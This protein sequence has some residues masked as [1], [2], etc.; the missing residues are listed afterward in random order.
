M[1][2]ENNNFHKVVDVDKLVKDSKSKIARYFP[3]FIISWIKKTLCQDELNI[4]H[5]KYLDKFGMDYVN[6]L[7]EELDLKITMHNEDTL[8]KAD[9]CIFVANHPL[10]AIDALSFLHCIHKL[11]GKVISPSNE[12][13][14][15]IPNLR[16]LIV[17]VN[18]FKRND[19]EHIDKINEVFLSDAQIMIFPAGL[20]SRKK[21]GQIKDLE[22]H[23][24]FVSKAIQ[25]KRFVIPTYITGKNS[26]KFYR[27]ARL[28]KFFGIKLPIETLYLPQEML[29]NKGFSIELTFGEP[30]PYTYFDR[31]KSPHEWAQQVRELVYNIA[32]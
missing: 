8:Q 23:K 2:K 30:I 9:R 19:K 10:G 24:S 16:P 15:Y 31:T 1:T 14:N 25:N 26:K 20:V 17:G 5:N 4:I 18:V 12:F 13:F 22:W 3:R 32:K 21:D 29:K 28:R 7:I 6:A 27:I 11:K